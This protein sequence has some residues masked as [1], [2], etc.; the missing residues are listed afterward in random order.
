MRT[1]IMD[2]LTNHDLAVVSTVT[3][4][5]KPESA[6]VGYYFDP[7]NVDLYF[8]T[9]ADSRKV[10]NLKTNPNLSVVVG[11]LPSTNTVQ[12]EGKAQILY[13][14]DSEF[15]EFLVRLAGLKILYKGP[16]LKI[17]GI[18]FVIVKTKITWLRWL[19]YNELTHKEEYFQLF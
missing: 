17:E 5:H 2:F 18:N 6:T 15:K 7:E 11:T 13:S 3:S 1:Q 8:V 10:K 19:D 4:D 12:M 14:G 16:F 9:R